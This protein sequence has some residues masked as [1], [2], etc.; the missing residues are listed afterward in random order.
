[1]ASVQSGELR[2]AV[3]VADYAWING[4]QSKIALESAVGLARRGIAV[5]VFAAVGPIDPDLTAAGVKVTCL[6]QTDLI[7]NPSRMNAAT[8]GLWN[9]AAAKS[10]RQL[11]AKTPVEGTVVHVHGWAKALSPSIAP[12]VNA[13]PHAWIYTQHEYFLACPTGTFFLFPKLQNCPHVPLSAGCLTENCD[14]RSAAHKAWRVVRQVALNSVGW[15]SRIGDFIYYSDLVREKL[16]PFM[17]KESRWH[18]LRSPISVA[19]M[20]R[21]Q[22]LSQDFVFVGRLSPEKGTL[23]FAEAARRLG[24]PATFV[25]EGYYRE[26][27][28][29]EYHGAKILGWKNQAEVQ[30]VLRGARALVFPSIWYETFGLSALESLACGTPVIVSDNCAARELISDGETGLLF[31]SGDVDDLAAKIDMLRDDALARRMSDAAYD[32]YWSDPS[33]AEQHVDMLMDIYRGLLAQSETL[34][35]VAV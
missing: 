9:F 2:R 16:A 3:I 10:L 33:T 12:V 29:R 17:N 26:V 19:P 8:A 30:A 11:L 23:L 24:I 4:G 20:G 34:R 32:R 35:L 18:R 25:G 28:A 5:D 6:D 14:P 15:P 31:R 21:K 1:M 13:S 22:A 7:G 27:L